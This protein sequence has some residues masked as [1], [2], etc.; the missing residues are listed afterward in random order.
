M[1]ASV[2]D[3]M[4]VLPHMLGAILEGCHSVRSKIRVTSAEV[5]NPKETVQTTE[6]FVFLVRDKEIADAISDAF[7]KYPGLNKR[8]D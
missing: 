8:G 2:T 1:K 5:V 6:M 7:D 4:E 3:I